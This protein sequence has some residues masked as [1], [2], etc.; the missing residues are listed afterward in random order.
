MSGNKQIGS[1]FH[2]ATL[3]YYLSIEKYEK[4]RSP[5]EHLQLIFSKDSKRFY[6]PKYIKNNRFQKIYKRK[7]NSESSNSDL[8]IKRRC[9]DSDQN[10]NTKLNV[11]E[12]T[13]K[14][15]KWGGRIEIDSK[16]VVI[17]NT[18]TIDYFILSIWCLSK[19]NS[20][21]LETD[22]DLKTKN[23]KQMILNIDNNNWNKAKEIW[24]TK[25]ADLKLE[26]NQSILST[27]GSEYDFFIKYLNQRQRHQLVQKCGAN[28][29]ENNRVL[30]ITDFLTFDKVD[31]RIEL[32]STLLRDVDLCDHDPLIA[33]EFLRK[34]NF[35]FI[36][37]KFESISFDELP[38]NI[39]INNDNFRL[40]CS[41]LSM[42]GH[43][44]AVFNINNE[45]YVVDDLDQSI[46][47][48]NKDKIGFWTSYSL[49]YLI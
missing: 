16:S 33:I 14:I 10:T 37:S 28:C 47:L 23:L 29:V 5:A 34:P 32:N 1:C 20:S 4:T 44:I 40:L 39:T 21:L 45:F 27:K 43:F 31:S 18:C 19:I 15:P 41:T 35:V 26:N 12:F 11:V 30:R 17:E 13:R 9:L 36:L 24:I 22:S 25:I 49:Y 46:F 3:I 38:K 8:N 6:Q 2:V 42:P 7:I 48:Y